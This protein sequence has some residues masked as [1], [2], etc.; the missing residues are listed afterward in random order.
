MRQTVVFRKFILP[1]VFSFM[2]TAVQA[3][4]V[5]EIEIP[6]GAKGPAIH[7][8]MWTPCTTPPKDIKIEGPL[9]VPGVRDCPIEGGK[10]PLIVVSHGG[11]GPVFE[12][13]DTAEVLA[14]AGF[15][16][17]AL[18]HPNDPVPGIDQS[19]L[20]ERPIDVQRLAEYMVRSSPAAAKIDPRRV[21]FFG[22]SRGGYTGLVL[23][24]AIADYPLLLKIWLQISV[25]FH[26]DLWTRPSGYDSR[27][28]AFVIADPLSFFTDKASLQNVKAPIQLWSSER[29]GSGVLPEK[30]AAVARNLPT[31]P[32][33]HQ[34]PN[35]AHPSFAF[36][37]MPAVA[38]VAV[39]F[40]TDPQGFDREAFHKDFNI[41]VLAFFR[42]TLRK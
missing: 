34:V 16:V 2:A 6:A 30:V 19:W 9:V 4:G 29:G 37:C 41:Q 22:F 8:M 39:E 35:S 25:A 28:K 3:A 40:C 12:H 7:A 33:F 36:P 15:I 10:L 23:A 20:V 1:I 42:K 11:G 18:K 21:G 32:E 26:K 31:R 14:D 27:F 17:V 5:K 24:G 38:K 13:H